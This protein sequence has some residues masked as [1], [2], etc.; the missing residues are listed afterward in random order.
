MTNQEQGNDNNNKE[1][2]N[3][4]NP[5]QFKTITDWWRQYSPLGW[6]ETFNE[7]LKYTSSMTEIYKEYI[8]N[9]EKMTRL[10]KE[11]AEN[12]ERMTELYKESVRVPERMTKHW[13]N[14][15]NIPSSSKEQI[16]DT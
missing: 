5:G 4:T 8:K 3:F 2:K 15:F 7:Y 1:A 6:A 9:S 13:L 16:R 14:K 10:Y 12:T 11:L